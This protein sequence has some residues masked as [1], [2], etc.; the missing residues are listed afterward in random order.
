MKNN[1]GVKGEANSAW[2]GDDVGYYGIH[3]WI[4]RELGQ[5][6]ECWRCGDHSDRKYEWA[7]IEHKYER[8]TDNWVRLCTPCHRYVDYT[9][10]AT[11]KKNGTEIIWKKTQTKTQ[12]TT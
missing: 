11:I 4:I 1:P 10:N 12:P 6:Q 3:K 9:G 7:S 8:D 5:P 2:K